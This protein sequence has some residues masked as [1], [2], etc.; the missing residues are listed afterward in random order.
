M[1]LIFLANISLEQ[2]NTKS[3]FLQVQTYVEAV[4]EPVCPVLVAVH[5]RAAVLE[6]VLVHFLYEL[7]QRLR[8]LPVHRR[9]AFLALDVLDAR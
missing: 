6:D 1:N 2:K 3:P 5:D 8:L 4:L 7:A 9:T